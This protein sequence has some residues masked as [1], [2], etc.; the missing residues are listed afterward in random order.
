M[1]CVGGGGT[2]I[3]AAVL[4]LFAPRKNYDIS[5]TKIWRKAI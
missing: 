2:W 1:G 4:A 5:D 3:L